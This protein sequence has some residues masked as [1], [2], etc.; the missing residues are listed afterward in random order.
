MPQWLIAVLITAFLGPL[1]V[2]A[3]RHVV[4]RGVKAIRALFRDKPE[5][6]RFT[7]RNR[8]RERFANVDVFTFEFTLHKADSVPVFLNGLY[9]VRARRGLLKDR[10]E[11]WEVRASP[12]ES[13]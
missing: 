12:T 7:W 3:I 13:G 6:F 11:A 2:P 9:L 1:L 4:V 8:F 10:N 5:N